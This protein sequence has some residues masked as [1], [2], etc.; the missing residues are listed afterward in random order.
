MD[1]AQA[2]VDQVLGSGGIGNYG[3]TVG[4]VQTHDTK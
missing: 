3:V 4:L 1:V 2:P